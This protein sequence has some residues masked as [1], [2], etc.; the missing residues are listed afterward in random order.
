VI[1]SSEEGAKDAMPHVT[2]K[3]TGKCPALEGP[4]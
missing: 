4:S 2:R 3:V 1:E